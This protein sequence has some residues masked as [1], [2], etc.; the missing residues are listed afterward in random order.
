MPEPS[1]GN[2]TW[3]S[4][5][6]RCA[7]AISA[8]QITPAMQSPETSALRGL[9]ESY[10]LNWLLNFSACL[11]IF[12]IEASS[13]SL[14]SSPTVSAQ[15][16]RISRMSLSVTSLPVNSGSSMSAKLLGTFLTLDLL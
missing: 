6:S 4:G 5:F 3:M 1:L 12:A 15:T 7:S 16:E 14:P 11:A 2:T 9:S 10:T 13:V 8:V